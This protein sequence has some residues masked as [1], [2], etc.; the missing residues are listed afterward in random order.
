[1]NYL[2]V[3]CLRSAL[4]TFS[5]AVLLTS[6]TTLRCLCVLGPN[7]Q[8]W[9]RVFSRHGYP[10]CPPS[11]IIFE[12]RYL[13]IFCE[14]TTC[15]VAEPCLSG[16]PVYRLQWFAQWWVPG[17]EPSPYLWTGTDHGRSA[18]VLW[19]STPF[20]VNLS[21]LNCLKRKANGTAHIYTGVHVALR[22]HASISRPTK[23][24]MLEDF[25]PVCF[26]IWEE[27]RAQPARRAGRC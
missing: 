18:I 25:L 19:S 3:C 11:L 20:I 21:E 13:S 14:V 7:V 12:R 6:L 4:E 10:S 9:I 5:L 2:F 23:L 1:M 27:T 22:G 8:A 17:W 16:T 26:L 24:A 15:L